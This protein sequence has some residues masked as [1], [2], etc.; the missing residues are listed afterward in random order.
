MRAASTELDT[1]PSRVAACAATTAVVVVHVDDGVKRAVLGHLHDARGG[2]GPAASGSSPNCA[3]PA[4]RASG[5]RS[6]EP[7]TTSTPSR[8]A[9]GS[10]NAFAR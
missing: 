8:R 9:A 6:S 1:S 7:T 4:R 2:P 10:M 5:P 3:P